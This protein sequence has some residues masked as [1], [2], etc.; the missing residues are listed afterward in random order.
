HLADPF[1][2]ELHPALQHVVHLEIKVVLVPAEAAMRGG[3]GADDMRQHLAAGC[4]ADA[5][6]A[7]FEAGSEAALLEDRVLRMRRREAHLGLGHG[8]LL[9][10]GFAAS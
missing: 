6:I 4:G 5:E 9:P 7:I 3:L 10:G 1:I 2:A 8:A